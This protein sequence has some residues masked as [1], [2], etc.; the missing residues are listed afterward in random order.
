MNIHSNMLSKVPSDPSP[1]LDM[2]RPDKPD[3]PGKRAAIVAA[4]CELM[5][6]SSF[7]GTPVPAVA[8]RA[9]VAI[10]TIYRY[11]PGKDALAN[12]VYRE[13]K[14]AMQGFL[15]E[16]LAGAES[17][18][19]GFSRL[20]RGLFAFARQHPAA[21]RFL[22][23]H[24]HQPYLDAASQ[25]VARRVFSDVADFVRTAQAH[26]AIRQAPPELLI[27]LAFGAFVGLMKEAEAGHVLLDDQAIE[28]AE[29]SVWRLFQPDSA[30]EDPR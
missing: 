25:E 27:A 13:A 17:A 21:F 10:G 16:A 30:Q 20:W 2:D 6:E 23:L 24:R 11:F 8:Q 1:T 22:E 26:G 19:D 15:H 5:G 18:R 14:L 29:E 9:G 4:A 7:G 28:H 12:A 3:R